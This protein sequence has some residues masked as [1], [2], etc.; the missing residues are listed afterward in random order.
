MMLFLHLVKRTPVDISFNSR[1]L[2]LFFA[3][4]AAVSTAP[5]FTAACIMAGAVA[6]SFEPMEF[7]IPLYIAPTYI[8]GTIGESSIRYTP[9]FALVFCTTA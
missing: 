9:Y 1:A 5:L 4:F 7:V 2:S 3:R 6:Q 8:N